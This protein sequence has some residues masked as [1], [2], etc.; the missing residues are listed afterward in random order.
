MIKYICDRCGSEMFTPYKVNVD[1]EHQ[2]SFSYDLCPSCTLAFRHWVED[3]SLIDG[4][5]SE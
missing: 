2:P 3:E 4:K 5:E 1:D